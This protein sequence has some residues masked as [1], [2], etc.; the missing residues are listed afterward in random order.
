MGVVD[1]GLPFYSFV[2]ITDGFYPSFSKVI[3]AEKIIKNQ[4]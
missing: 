2:D 3:N 4:Y 1:I